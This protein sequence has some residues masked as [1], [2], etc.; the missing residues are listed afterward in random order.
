MEPVGWT[1]DNTR[2]ILGGAVAFVS[3]EEEFADTEKFLRAAAEEEEEEEELPRKRI[4]DDDD[5]G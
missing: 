1:P 3:S 2:F 5:D 4:V